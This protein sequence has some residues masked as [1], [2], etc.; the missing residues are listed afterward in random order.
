M[1]QNQATDTICANDRNMPCSIGYSAHHN[2]PVRCGGH[3]LSK[4]NASACTPAYLADG[5]PVSCG[6][7]LSLQGVP[8]QT[9]K[10]TAHTLCD[11]SIS[12]RAQGLLKKHSAAH[13]CTTDNCAMTANVASEYS[14]ALEG[15]RR[16]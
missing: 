8:V 11:N 2:A 9:A 12:H 5:Q 4:D 3:P 13:L 6:C 16:S 10:Q 15:S 1:P 14:L 7:P